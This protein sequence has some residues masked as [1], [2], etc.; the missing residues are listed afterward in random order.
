MALVWPTTG[1]AERSPAAV[2]GTG[3]VVMVTVPPSG[4]V[5]VRP[6]HR[7]SQPGVAAPSTSKKPAAHGPRP[8]WP[9]AQRAVALSGVEHTTPQPP[10]FETSLAMPASQPLGVM[11]EPW[12]QV[13]PAGHV[14]PVQRVSVQTPLSHVLPMPQLV[15]PQ[16]SGL[17]VPATH[18]SPAG[19]RTFTQRR[20]SQVTSFT[21]TCVAAQSMPGQSFLK[22]WPVM[23]LEVEGHC[24]PTQATSVQAPATQ[25]LP[26][27]QR[28]APHDSGSQTPARQACPEGHA[29]FTQ[30]RSW[31]AT[32]LTQTCSAAHVAESQLFGRQRLPAQACVEGHATPHAPQFALSSFVSTQVEPHSVVVVPQVMEP[33][34][35]PKSVTDCRQA[36]DVAKTTR[37]PKAPSRFIR[38]LN[39]KRRRD[40]QRPPSNGQ[41]QVPGARRYDDA[42]RL[43]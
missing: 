40:D 16:L 17:H 42:P 32:L 13:F 11:H 21:Q 28:V 37:S 6:V 3:G 14:M 25:T 27:T 1:L 30:S 10:Q 2:S 33:A 4:S 18:D 36:E 5:H 22:H 20:S 12:L 19:Q 15:A 38:F 43:L 41:E 8:H 24:T 35:L 34:S 29:T 9:A 31:Q 7:D 23:Q 26:G 39:A